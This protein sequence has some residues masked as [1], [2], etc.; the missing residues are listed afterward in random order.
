MN[1]QQLEILIPLLT[2]F[3]GAVATLIV[4]VAKLRNRNQTIATQQAIIAANSGTITPT[5]VGNGAAVP[6]QRAKKTFG[7]D[8]TL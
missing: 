1:S 2:A 3:I 6:I 5:K 4:A 7:R 8:E